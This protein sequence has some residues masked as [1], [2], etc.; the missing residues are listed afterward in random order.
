MNS[1]IKI[2]AYVRSYLI[3]KHCKDHERDLFD[4]MFSSASSDDHILISTLVAKIL[5]FYDD[6]QDFSRLVTDVEL[7]ICFVL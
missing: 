1:T 2:Q 5:F 4:S 3:R 6:K 7:F